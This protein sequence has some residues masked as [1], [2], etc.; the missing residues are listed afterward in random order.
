MMNE[1]GINGSALLG[2]VLNRGITV[3]SDG[4]RA[5]EGEVAN[6]RAGNRSR[7]MFLSAP[8]VRGPGGD[9]N[10]CVIGSTSDAVHSTSTIILIISA[11]GSVAAIRRGIVTC[12]GG[13]NVPSILILGGVSVCSERRVTRAVRGCTS[14]RSFSTFIPVDTEDKGGISRIVSRYSGFL[15]RSP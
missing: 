1:P 3:I 14:G 2:S 8:N 15:S 9:L 7:F 11:N 4:P 6:V 13:D 5:A 12:L 10:R